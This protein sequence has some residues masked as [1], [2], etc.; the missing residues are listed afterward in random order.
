MKRDEAREDWS[1]RCSWCGN[2]VC[3]DPISQPEPEVKVYEC[4]TCGKKVEVQTVN[5]KTTVK[6]LPEEKPETTGRKSA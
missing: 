5:G 2:D 1:L 3:C 4:E 6:C